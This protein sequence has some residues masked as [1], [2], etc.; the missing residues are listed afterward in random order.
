M[1]YAPMVRV[2]VLVAVS[3]MFTNMATAAR[4]EENVTTVKQPKAIVEDS[5]EHNRIGKTGY[6]SVQPLGFAVG[7]IPSVGVNAGYYLSRNALLQLEYSKGKLPYIFFSI[8]ATTVGLN[9][10]YFVGNSFYIKSGASYRQ[11]AVKD[12]TCFLCDTATFQDVG[13]ADS[14][15]VEVAIGN[16]WQWENFTMGCDWF[17][18]MVPFTT[19]NISNN[20]KSNSDLSATT[21][22]DLDKAWYNLG[23]TTSY[24]LLRFYLGA[25]F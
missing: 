14:A 6:L 17:G 21:K 5:S 23:R 9:L 2:L 18:A 22:S 20:Y 24:E 13:S 15:A 7:A 25:S 1:K 8:E 10:K 4:S 16:Q 11:V 19:T 12:L 3:T